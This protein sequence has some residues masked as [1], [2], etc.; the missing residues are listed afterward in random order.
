MSKTILWKKYAPCGNFAHAETFP[1][2]HAGAAW[3]VGA[4]SS[5]TMTGDG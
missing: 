1:L 2:R 3:L 5:M 4:F